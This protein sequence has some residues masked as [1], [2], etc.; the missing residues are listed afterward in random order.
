MKTR[1]ANDVDPDEIALYEPSHLDLRYMHIFFSVLVCQA[2]RVNISFCITG[3]DNFWLYAAL[4][5]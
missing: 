1:M 4:K 5:T 2:E 3:R